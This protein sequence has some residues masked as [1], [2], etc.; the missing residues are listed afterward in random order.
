MK[1]RVTLA[2]FLLAASA[3]WAADAQTSFKF[4]FGS[5]PAAPGYTLVSPTSVYSKDTGYGFEPGANITAVNR[6]GGDPL[7]AGFVTSGNLFKFSVAVPEGNYQVTVTLGDAQA[8]STTTVKAESRRL[9]LERIHTTPG[10][11][12]TRTFYVS[13]RNPVLPDGTKIKLDVQ[14]IDA[15]GQLLT[16]TWDDKLTL[17]FSDTQPALCAVE[18]QPAAKPITVFL[19]S[20]STVTDQ[21]A[22]PYGT[23]GQMLPRWFKPPVVIANFAESGETLKAF[24]AEHRWDKIMGELQPGDYVFMQF[25]TNDLNKTGHNAIWPADDHAGDWANTYV[26]GEDYKNLLKQYAAEVKAKGGIP[27]IVSP[28]T[29]IDSRTGAINPTGLRNYPKDAMD[30]AKEA[31]IASIDLNAMSIEVDQALNLGPAMAQRVYTAEGL[32]QRTYGGYLFSRCIVEG[33]K[34]DKLDLAKYLVDDAGTFDP[35]HPLPL[36][37]D[38]KV[39]LEPSPAGG[40][41]GGFGRG[42]AGPAASAPTPPAAAPAAAPAATSGSSPAQ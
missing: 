13:V 34:Q 7:R 36:P 42:P 17:Q 23:W 38:F 22:E 21:R 20:D 1:H 40:R 31:G 41:R 33:I 4:Q 10:Q 19:A 25:G 35:N 6:G 18:I 24:R 39:P 5:S 32:H 16:P 15:N 8:E 14:E 11:F 2:A 29:K 30:A 12:E 3:A 9:M 26:E 37:D 28:M 27:V